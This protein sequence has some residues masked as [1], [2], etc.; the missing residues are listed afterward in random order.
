MDIT[1]DGSGTGSSQLVA[2]FAGNPTLIASD[3]T[4]I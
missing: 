1:P 3:I 2:N 4:I